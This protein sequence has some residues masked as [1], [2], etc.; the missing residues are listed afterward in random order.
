MIIKL[1]IIERGNHVKFSVLM[2]VYEKED[3]L[4][5]DDALKS[6]LINQSVI[7]NELVLV[8]DG[9]LTEQLNEVI[10][11]YKSRFPNLINL[12][13]LDTN[14][15]LGEA[16]KIGLNHC[17]YDLVARM[18]SD[19]I[20]QRLRFEKQLH[21]LKENPDVDLVGSNIAEFFKIPTKIEFIREVPSTNDEI[22]KMVK[23]RNPINHV[24][25]MFKKNVVIK[26]GSYIHLPFLEDYYLWIRMISNKAEM[27]NIPESL[28]YVRTGEKM[29]ERRSNPEIMAGWYILQKEMNKYN[30][31]NKYDV[32]INVIRMYLFIQTPSKLKEYLYKCLLRKKG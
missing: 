16:L 5:L 9:P 23:R 21:Y 31:I 3:P 26:S 10:L 17:R 7:P 12:I 13:E 19:D 24:S 22:I 11:Y 20:S 32:I 25:V 18:D 8:K 15:G 30:I 27:A 29:F 6:I 28:V 2:S 4:Y 1:T 14:R